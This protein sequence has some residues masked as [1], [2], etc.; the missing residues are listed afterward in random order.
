MLARHAVLLTPSILLRLR[1]NSHGIISFTDPHPLTLLESYR[2]KNM[3]RGA[4]LRFQR[5]IVQPSNAPFAFRLGSRDVPTFNAQTFPPAWILTALAATLMDPLA[6]VA[7]KRLTA[8]LSPL[9]ATLT[10][11]TGGGVSNFPARLSL[12]AG[13]CYRLS[14]YPPFPIP[15]PLSFHIL[16]V[17]SYTTAPAQLFSIQ[18]VTH[19]FPRD[20]GCTPSHQSPITSHQPRPSPTVPVLSSPLCIRRIAHSSRLGGHH[21]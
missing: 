16:A 5:S 9:N 8:W 17:L 18:P 6:N 11:N 3:G 21:E 13:T 4:V 2:L 7:N 20:G 10:K 19:S 12:Q 15:Y 14:P 1:P